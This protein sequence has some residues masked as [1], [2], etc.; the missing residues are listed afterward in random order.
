MPLRP[1]VH[2]RPNASRPTPFGLTT[3]IPVITT[4]A[5]GEIGSAGLGTDSP[6]RSSRKTDRGAAAAA[7]R[8]IIAPR[9]RGGGSIAGPGADG[10]FCAFHDADGR[11][12]VEP[13]G[14]VDVLG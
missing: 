7:A 1:S 4:R 10:R 2:A 6:E 8:P 3:P 14:V 12:H 13:R 5:A 9:R 11:K